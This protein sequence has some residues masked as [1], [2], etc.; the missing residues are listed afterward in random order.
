MAPQPRGSFA[1]ACFSITLKGR[2]KHSLGDHLRQHLHQQVD[3]RRLPSPN[4]PANFTRLQNRYYS[5]ANAG[6]LNV[7]R[8]RL[9]H[10]NQPCRDRA[11]G[12][13][14]KSGKDWPWPNG[15]NSNQ[16][17]AETTQGQ[18]G[19]ELLPSFAEHGTGRSRL[20]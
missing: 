11:P 12:K 16:Q 2:P 7:F 10:F 6:H 3:D 19:L 5:S 1:A 18:I 17:K 8:A 14:G 13:G 4:R 9:Q 15:L 20:K